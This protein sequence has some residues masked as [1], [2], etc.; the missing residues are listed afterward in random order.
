MEFTWGAVDLTLRVINLA[1]IFRGFVGEQSQFRLSLVDTFTICLV[2]ATQR[3]ED[4][5]DEQQHAEAGMAQ[6]W[7][8]RA[9]AATSR[10]CWASQEPT[11]PQWEGLQN[12]Q[13]QQEESLSPSVYVSESACLH[14]HRY[15]SYTHRRNHHPVFSAGLESVCC[16]LTDVQ[17]EAVTLLSGSSDAP[18]TKQLFS[19]SY[20]W[21]EL[22]L[23]RYIQYLHIDGCAFHYYKQC[24]TWNK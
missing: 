24:G 17:R 19:Q 15:Y 12:P 3:G 1:Q 8:V 16:G 22:S 4:E 13:T 9:P 14:T 6:L 7:P 18:A 21:L 20:H 5:E 10:L 2:S 23:Y 11:L